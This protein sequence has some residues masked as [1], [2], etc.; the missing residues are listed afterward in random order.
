MAESR[1][2]QGIV[3]QGNVLPIYVS[4]AFERRSKAVGI[5]SISAGNYQH[6]RL[7]RLDGFT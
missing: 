3:L 7:V 6:L 2:P 5:I 1:R 4:L